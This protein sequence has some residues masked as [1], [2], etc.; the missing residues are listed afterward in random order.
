MQE[1]GGILITRNTLP[2]QLHRHSY[3]PVLFFIQ[4]EGTFI[5]AHP[6]SLVIVD[7]TITILHAYIEV[8]FSFYRVI[9]KSFSGRIEPAD[10]FLRTD[11]QITVGIFIQGEHC[12]MNKRIAVILIMKPFLTTYTIITVESKRSS[13]PDESFCILENA[14]NVL[15]GQSFIRADMLKPETGL[16]KR[17][18]VQ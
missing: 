10:A 2:A 13:Y 15:I 16:A 1:R 6:N 12:I 8:A 17:Y 18:S 5:W 7:I 3:K 14:V 4:P 11:P 9:D